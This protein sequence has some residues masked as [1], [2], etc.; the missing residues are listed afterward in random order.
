MLAKHNMRLA[1]ENWCWSTHAPSWK[2]AW[3]IVRQIDKHN[4]GLCL[5]T[6][7][8]PGSEW[9][10]PTNLSGKIED[11]STQN[12][13]FKDVS[14]LDERFEQS[15]KELERTIPPEKIYLLQISDA[16]KPVPGPLHKKDIDGIRPR[17][18]WSHS[19][20]PMPYQG[21]YLPVEAVTRA[22]LRTGFKE[23]FSVE[24]FDGGPQG[25]GEEYDMEDF[26]GEAKDSLDE[27][28]RRC[29]ITQ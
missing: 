9:A 8:I 20:R 4:V 29:A 10:D 5:D 12:P 2:D 23:W 27:L 26:A 22:V 17:A 7:Q 6:F 24:V 16:Y 1:Y 21:G 3:D 18:R 15:L 25:E 28:I 14:P 13:E 19:F 11:E